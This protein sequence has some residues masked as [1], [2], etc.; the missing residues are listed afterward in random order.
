MAG[1]RS[2]DQT[3]GVVVIQMHPLARSSQVAIR[4]CCCVMLDV[5]WARTSWGS[6][7][8][9]YLVAILAGHFSIGTRERPGGRESERQ[10]FPVAY[11]PI[12][13]TGAT[14]HVP[15]GGHS[16]VHAYLSALT[17]QCPKCAHRGQLM[18][19]LE[20][21]NKCQL[22]ERSQ[23]MGHPKLV[24]PEAAANMTELLT[25]SSCSFRESPV[26]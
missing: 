23:F 11:A 8:S 9:H 18:G 7:A 12:G 2:D 26:Y 1:G 10:T 3:I 4:A 24:R 13:Q 14:L 19:A 6:C 17:E 16:I 5:I 22:G 15:T 20:R 25:R 21:A